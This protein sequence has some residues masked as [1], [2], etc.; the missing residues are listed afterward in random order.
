MG[1]R[2]YMVSYDWNIAN[3]LV[4]TTFSVPQTILNNQLIVGLKSFYTTTG[5][6][7]LSFQWLPGTYSG[8]YGLQMVTSSSLASYVM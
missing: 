2:S 1:A 6:T 7:S 8:Y 3:P 4:T 5:Q